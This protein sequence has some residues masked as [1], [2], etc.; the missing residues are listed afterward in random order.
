MVNTI[1]AIFRANQSLSL[2]LDHGLMYPEAYTVHDALTGYINGGKMP[3][4]A[5]IRSRLWPIKLSDI[6]AG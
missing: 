6:S 4:V 2:G 1:S 3:K 5:E